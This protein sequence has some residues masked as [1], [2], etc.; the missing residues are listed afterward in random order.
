M[1]ALILGL[2]NIGEKYQKTRHNLGF[3]VVEKMI[4][5]LDAI[6]QPDTAL[7]RWAEAKT[8]HGPVILARPTTYMNRSGWAAAEL[9][10]RHELDIR[11]MLVVVDDFNLPLGALRIRKSGSDGGHNGLESTIAHLASENFPRM[12][13]GIGSPPDNISVT[14]F[15]LSRFGQ[16]EKERADDTTNIAA[17]AATYLISHSLDEAMSKFNRN[18]A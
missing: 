16:E 10:E 17:E 7:Y 3:D 4:T 11:Q 9:L 14:D 15:V 6:P 2:G 13:L 18:P 5:K 1:I 8:D 12:R